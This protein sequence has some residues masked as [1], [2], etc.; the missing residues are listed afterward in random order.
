MTVVAAILSI[1]PQIICF[2]HYRLLP[3]STCCIVLKS[4]QYV[5]LWLNVRVQFAPCGIK[6]VKCI[7]YV[8][9]VFK[10]GVVNMWAIPDCV[11]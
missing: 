8:F 7:Y 1:F 10:I 2:V 4:L 9:V 11:I 6:I 5:L 3:G